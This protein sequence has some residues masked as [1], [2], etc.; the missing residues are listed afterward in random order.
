[1]MKPIKE[2]NDKFKVIAHFFGTDENSQ[3]Q[4][5]RVLLGI[6]IY[7]SNN[8]HTEK[9]DKIADNLRKYFK[10]NNSRKN[11]SP[12][13]STGQGIIGLLL[14]RIIKKLKKEGNA[15]DKQ[16]LS[17]A[18]FEGTAK[19]LKAFLEQEPPKTETGILLNN[20]N[21]AISG[22]TDLHHM[23]FLI[24]T[25]PDKLSSHVKST[26]RVDQKFYYLSPESDGIWDSIASHGG[27]KQY[28]QCR[29]ALEKLFESSVC[30]N[31]FTDGQI[32]S[33]V[34]LGGG[35]ASKDTLII[36]EV[37]KLLPPNIL[38]NY[39]IIDYSNYMLKSTFRKIYSY[40]VD[41]HLTNRVNLQIIE[42]DFL[43]L[44]E[45]KEFRNAYKNIAWM[46]P[47]GTIGNIKEGAFLD[48]VSSVAMNG[49]LLF[50]GAE[51]I[52]LGN[53]KMYNEIIDKY[54]NQDVEKYLLIPLKSI[55]HELNK[56][57]GIRNKKIHTT[58]SAIKGRDV[59][60]VPGFNNGHSDVIGSGTLEISLKING[61][62]YILFTSTRYAETGLI[63]F[64]TKKKFSHKTSIA[65]P[66]ED[67][68]KYFVFS[69]NLPY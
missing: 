6:P 63:N 55:W 25:E 12:S 64:V 48:S 13:K 14:D 35:S 67:R 7:E 28:N 41:R 57:N 46:I 21:L 38:L 26:R 23:L 29:S 62:K 36:E 40:L 39:T 30:D 10:P 33:I 8:S 65:S 32:D 47:G 11:S 1:M 34:M 42:H 27:Y 22:S 56:E 52:E 45:I 2:P 24:D 19:E 50:I 51:T 49:D 44:Q 69:M 5:A 53:N 66:I 43:R 37:L 31:F 20:S 3:I 4:L 18:L 60:I 68:Y 59:K 58:E 61:Q 16:E 17:K 9:A 54:K 15:C